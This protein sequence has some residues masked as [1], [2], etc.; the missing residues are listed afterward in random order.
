MNNSYDLLE[1][2]LSFYQ[3][4]EKAKTNNHIDLSDEEWMYPTE[5]L[6]IVV[7]LTEK[8]TTKVSLPKDGEVS[9]YYEYITK[10]Y[11]HHSASRTTLPMLSIPTS[12]LST[13]KCW[14]KAG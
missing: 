11:R 5:L 8:P 4:K 14:I 9:G 12:V 2:Y 13:S 7:L 1:S 10:D 3:I 6:P